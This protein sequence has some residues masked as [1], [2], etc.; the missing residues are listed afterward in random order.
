MEAIVR[1]SAEAVAIPEAPAAPVRPHA[2]ASPHGTRIDEYYWLRDDT[3]TAPDVLRYLAAENAYTDAMLARVKPLEERLYAEIV[4]RIKQDDAS[5]PY[6]E[7]GYWY[8]RRYEAGQ[9]YPVYA[10]R[11][12]MLDAPEQ[13]LLDVVELARGSAFYRIGAFEVSP[14]EQ[15]LV[16][17][18][19]AVGRRQYTL[20][21]RDLA[22]GRVL[23]DA[24][25][26]AEAATAWSGDG[27]SVLY[28]EKDPQTLLGQ[29]VRRHVLGTDPSTDELVYEETDDSY[30]VDV[31]T[32]KDGRYVYI[33]CENTV[34]S[35]QRVADAL[36]PL[37][38]FRVLVSR[39]RDHEYQADH[40]EGRWIL[41]TNWQAPNFRVVEIEADR[42]ADRSAWRDLVP[43]RGDAFVHGFSVFRGFLA[44]EER[45]EGLRRVRIR[46]WNGSTDYT[47]EAD[48]PAYLA[49]LG[50][51]EEIDTGV[52]RYT[53]TSLTTPVT[54]YDYDVASGHRTL[55]KREPVL[56]DFDPSNYATE[57]R[58]VPAR[59]GELI[60]VAIV[61][62]KGFRRDG[63]APL[64]Q[65][66]YGAYGISIDPA[67]G[68]A[69]LSLL[70]RGFVYAI[71]QV[72]GGQE[73]GRRW[74]D[75]GRLVQKW[76]TFND[77]V[78][79]TRFLVQEGYADPQRVF[80]SGGSAGGLLMGVIA[81]VAPRD[82]RAILADVPFVDVLT[83][84]LDE[85]IPL[86][87]NEYDEWGN[88]VE[89]ACYEYLRSYSPYDN[90]VPQDYP[91]MLV[92]TGLWDSQVQYFEPA[93]W[94]AR[95]RRLRTN[96]APLLLRTH[97]EAGHG[98]RSGRFQQYRELAEAYAFLLDQAG[99][100]G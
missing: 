47:L 70:D 2:V 87:T 63:T 95:L 7:R 76:N 26:N 3:R 13:V 75:A 98:G 73:L 43:H 66:G 4:G 93:K 80:A 28:I 82:Y 11:K 30:Y 12:G 100:A 18:E 78:D 72:R 31:G 59:D 60:P 91:A 81:N 44:V 58:R 79:V 33:H 41:R 88:P 23:D 20:R 50:D 53:Y 51:N 61:Y 71:A 8:Y 46:P 62:R 9:E 64:L 68:S 99:L 27:R 56:G 36:D 74:Y 24:I 38:S 21:F 14:D 39:E 89:R 6:R 25:P 83:T 19:D 32:T 42:V 5:V 92:T 86:T 65:Y 84:M 29:R 90:V 37:L 40:F 96:R 17:A 35:E 15:L 48:E 22:T 1:P 67:F 55:L 52:V 10:R 49:A 97:M 94:V 77:F 16:Y 85:S 57:Y 69:R 34:S 45:S 54:T